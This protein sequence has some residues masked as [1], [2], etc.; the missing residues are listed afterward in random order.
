MQLKEDQK[1]EAYMVGKLPIKVGATLYE[2]GDLVPSLGDVAETV[3]NQLL[4]SH[5]LYKVA[6]V[7]HAT[8]KR[9]AK[10][11]A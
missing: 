4:D 6:V 10:V 9:L 2:P 5:R 1:I 3:K 8:F 11:S 7:T